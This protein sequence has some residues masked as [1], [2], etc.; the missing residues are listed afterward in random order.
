MEQYFFPDTTIPINFAVI[1]RLD[2][3]VAYLRGRGRMTQAVRAEVR[4]SAGLVPNLA[5]LD[6]ESTFGMVIELDRESDARAVENLRKRFALRGDA[7]TKHL[8]ES[9][10]LH[11]LTTRPEFGVSRFVTEDRAAYE[12]AGKMSVLRHHTMDVFHE[13]VINGE[14]GASEAFDLLLAIEDGGHE[15][16]LIARPAHPNQLLA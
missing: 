11:V 7:P 6:V 12:M 3:L 5:R 4:K 14:L 16:T 8:G 9:E 2:L 10:T 15:R 1:D 13:L